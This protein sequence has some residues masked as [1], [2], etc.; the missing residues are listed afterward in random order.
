MK[1]N[2]C[3]SENHDPL[4]GKVFIF[5]ILGP[6]QGITYEFLPL[7]ETFESPVLAKCTPPPLELLQTFTVNYQ[8]QSSFLTTHY[9]LQKE[10]ALHFKE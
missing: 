5:V 8:Q 3:F 10:M 4:R 6:F 1:A 7:L 9:K 2:K